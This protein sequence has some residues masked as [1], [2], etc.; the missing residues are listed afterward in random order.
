[1]YQSANGIKTFFNPALA[2][3]IIF[4]ISLPSTVQ[5]QGQD[6]V[7]TPTIRQELWPEIDAYYRF[8]DKFRLFGSYSATKLKTSSYTD[9]GLSINLDYFA[10]PVWR[11]S[12]PRADSTRGS[13]LWLRGGFAYS[14]SP[15]DVEN[16]FT[17]YTIVTEV[18]AR[19][20]LPWEILLTQRNRFDWRW[21]NGDFKPRY[22]AKLNV[23]KAFKTDYLHFTVYTYGE[24]FVNINSENPD[25]FRWALGWEVRASKHLSFET[26]FVHQFEGSF[27]SL[28]VNA[29]GL[30]AKIYFHKGDH[31]FGKKKTEKSNN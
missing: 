1:M 26:Y 10:L 19:F 20:Y 4:F 6:S 13:L 25:I 2:L 17:D 24:F 8:N 29:V 15:K 12:K 7:I 28:S 30:A 3:M 23:E 11:K 14:H 16:T 5:S 22:R 31:L 18:S 27:N 21:R 9:G